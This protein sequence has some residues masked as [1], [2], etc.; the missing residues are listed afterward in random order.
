MCRIGRHSAFLRTSAPPTMG[1]DCRSPEPRL[2]RGRGSAPEHVLHQGRLPHSCCLPFAPARIGAGR[3]GVGAAPCSEFLWSVL[4]SSLPCTDTFSAALLERPVTP[5]AGQ[6]RRVLRAGD[7]LESRL[8]S[9]A[10]WGG[11]LSPPDRPSLSGCSWTEK[12]SVSFWAGVSLLN[13]SVLP[14][15]LVNFYTPPWPHQAPPSLAM[16]SIL[17]G[18]GPTSVLPT[19]PSTPPGQPAP[20]LWQPRS[21]GL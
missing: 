21:S 9:D 4:G 14:Y 3:D 12:L 8:P 2:S 10:S 15:S 17:S 18:T 5:P 1:S 13:S 16:T 20:A 6:P 19:Y 11:C 7:R